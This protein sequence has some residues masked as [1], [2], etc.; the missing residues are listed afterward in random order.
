VIVF[1]DDV[2]FVVQ[3]NVSGPDQYFWPNSVLNVAESSMLLSANLAMS[4][5]NCSFT[6]MGLSLLM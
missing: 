6:N 4:L 2:V 1:D 3:L 5:S